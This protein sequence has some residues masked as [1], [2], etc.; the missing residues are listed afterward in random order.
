[1]NQCH[2]V[3]DNLADVLVHIV[4]DSPPPLEVDSI[5][6]PSPKNYGLVLVDYMEPQPMTN[7][8]H[9]EHASNFDH[10]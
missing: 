8:D 4:V 5:P 1:V 6:I 7:L 9:H 2:T 10:K 3:E